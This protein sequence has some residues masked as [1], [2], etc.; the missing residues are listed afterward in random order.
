VIDFFSCILWAGM[1]GVSTWPNGTRK[2][3][4]QATPFPEPCLEG[5]GGD[6]LMALYLI[7][8]SIRM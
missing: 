6:A 7:N 4:A 8:S 1:T 2:N 3:M 5:I